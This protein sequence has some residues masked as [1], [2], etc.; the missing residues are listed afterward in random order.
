MTRELCFSVLMLA[1]L[2]G[3]ALAETAALF[4]ASGDCPLTGP[5][6]A[7]SAACT[8]L[9]VR[10]QQA[11]SV[12]LQDRRVKAASTAR[13]GVGRDISAPAAR[14]RMVMCRAEVDELSRVV[15]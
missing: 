14:A 8:A 13:L 3:P 2:A 11:M 10:Y 15:E 5:V 7:P 12:C 6:Q 9:R 4:D 1:L